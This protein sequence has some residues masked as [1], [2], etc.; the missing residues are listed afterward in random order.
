[1][2]KLINYSYK[3][4]SIYHKNIN[5]IEIIEKRIIKIKEFLQKS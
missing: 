5:S 4:T 3:K 2:L 1:M